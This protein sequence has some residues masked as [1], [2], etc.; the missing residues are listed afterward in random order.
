MFQCP[1]NVVVPQCD[2]LGSMCALLWV[3]L[4]VSMFALPPIT[5][6]L[7]QSPRDVQVVAPTEELQS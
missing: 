5:G 6:E 4:A 7:L 1:P 2:D 3:H